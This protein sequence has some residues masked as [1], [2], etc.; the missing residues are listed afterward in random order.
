[1]LNIQYKNALSG[2][3]SQSNGARPSF[4]G[5]EAESQHIYRIVM[6]ENVSVVELDET[7]LEEF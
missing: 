2:F 4:E 1:M 6:A 5:C 3:K 7:M